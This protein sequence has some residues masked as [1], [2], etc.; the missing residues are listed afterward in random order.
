MRK[1]Q[2]G[3]TLI[4]LIIVIVILGVLSVIAA[5][6]LIDISS[7]ARIA[8]LKALSGNIKSASN[9]V[10]AKAVIQ[11]KQNESLG[12]AGSIDIDGDG[13]GDL[14]IHYGYPNSGDPNAL[15]EIL[16][17]EDYMT[18][19]TGY[20]TPTPILH[21]ANLEVAANYT[22]LQASNCY[23]TYARAVSIGASPTIILVTSGC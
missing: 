23:L 6:K 21:V 19:R 17:M 13:T 5:P 16:N 8:E 14:L 3:F 2:G 12:N 22:A 7:D 9:L 10:Y 18:H 15:S 1:I 11:G 20:G 4:E